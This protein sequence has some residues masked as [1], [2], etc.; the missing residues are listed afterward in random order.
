VGSLALGWILALNASPALAF[1]TGLEAGATVMSAQQSTLGYGTAGAATFGVIIDQSL[2]LDSKLFFDPWMDF[3]A[4]LALPVYG[5]SASYW[6]IDLGL[7]FGIDLGLFS[8]YAGIVGQ[9]LFLYDPV[10]CQA[11][12]FPLNSDVLALGGDLGLNLALD[13]LSFGVELR[14]LVTFTPLTQQMSDGYATEFQGLGS[15]RVNW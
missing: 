14:Y 15:V 10:D 6:A 9:L 11:C 12:G 5:L 8:P 7:R 3:Q 1:G 4:P 13:V 2:H